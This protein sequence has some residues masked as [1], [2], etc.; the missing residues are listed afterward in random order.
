MKLSYEWKKLYRI[1]SMQDTT[2]QGLISPAIFEKA[3]AQC[4]AYLTKED[5]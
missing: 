1:L 4:G 5:L 2:A 3:A